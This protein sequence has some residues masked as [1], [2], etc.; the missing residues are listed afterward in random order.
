MELIEMK[1][2]NGMLAV[3]KA[4]AIERGVRAVPTPDD[5]VV[6]GFLLKSDE[7]QSL[8]KREGFRKLTTVNDYIETWLEI[9]HVVRVEWRQ[10]SAVYFFIL[11]STDSLPL[12]DLMECKQDHDESHE[13]EVYV[14]VGTEV[15]A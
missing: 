1:G 10:H 11:Q 5:K 7:L 13:A 2:I 9:G 8:F 3:A 14:Y 12:R 4:A 6:Y 15:M